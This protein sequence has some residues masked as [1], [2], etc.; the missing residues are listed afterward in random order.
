MW[1]KF[2]QQLLIFKSIFT[3]WKFILNFNFVKKQCGYIFLTISESLKRSQHVN[4]FN[5]DFKVSGIKQFFTTFF[6]VWLFTPNSVL[7]RLAVYA[8]FRFRTFG[9]TGVKKQ[10][11]AKAKVV[12]TKKIAIFAH[13]VNLKT[14]DKIQVN[15][16]RETK[17]HAEGFRFICEKLA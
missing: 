4:L 8:E 12:N 5:F 7:E 11:S 13:M 6:S 17:I 14:L 1:E 10:N 2:V 15:L 9:Y 3:Q 16:I